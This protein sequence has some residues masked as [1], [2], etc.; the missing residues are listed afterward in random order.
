MVE[1]DKSVG[2]KAHDQEESK[3]HNH[4]EN[5]VDQFHRN[6]SSLYPVFTCC[7]KRG[8]REVSK[9]SR[10]LKM[11]VFDDAVTIISSSNAGEGE[12]HGTMACDAVPLGRDLD[13]VF[14]PH[15]LP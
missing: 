15:F 11:L 4:C 14:M 6:A 5:P 2:K 3:K 10:V 8:W 9:I 1:A 13:G 7:D 12:K